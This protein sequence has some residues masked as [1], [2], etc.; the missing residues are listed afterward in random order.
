M[1][2]VRLRPERSVGVGDTSR[3]GFVGG[4]VAMSACTRVFI[5][6][7]VSESL[8]LLNMLE[9]TSAPAH[10]KLDGVAVRIGDVTDV[11]ALAHDFLVVGEPELLSRLNMLESTSAAAAHCDAD[12]SGVRGVGD[13]KA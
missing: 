5:G 3:A 11:D 2:R 10:R 13:V 12:V 6:A 1:L 9:S 4:V 7:R 8:L